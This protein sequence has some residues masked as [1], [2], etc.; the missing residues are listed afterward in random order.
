MVDES[1]RPKYRDYADYIVSHERAPGHRPARRL[2]RRGRR[3]RYGKRRAQSEP[4]A[5]LHRQW[6]LLAPRARRRP[7]L[8]QDGQSRLSGIRRGD[9]LPGEARADR[10]PALFGAAAALPPRRARAWRRCCRRRASAG[11]SRR[12]FD[13]LPIWYAPFE[14]AMTDNAAF[15]LHAHHAAPHAHVPFVGL[16][17]RLAEADHQPE[18]PLHPSRDR[19]AAGA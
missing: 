3:S 6:R 4:A 8:L 5:A 15:D 1:G 2:A 19:R 18:P 12:Y 14:E 17:E 13:P 10:L 9:G 16:A 7:A 11:G